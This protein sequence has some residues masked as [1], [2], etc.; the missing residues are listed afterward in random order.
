MSKQPRS[1]FKARR[2]RPWMAPLAEAIEKHHERFQA[3]M[4]TEVRTWHTDRCPYPRGR[5]ACTC[6]P[7]E[8]EIEVVDPLRN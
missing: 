1:I 4:V 3:G 2:H 5:G 8:I 7:G 6:K